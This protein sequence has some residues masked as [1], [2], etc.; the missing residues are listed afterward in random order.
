M[1]VLTNKT[2]NE[3][4]NYKEKY[5]QA[6][7]EIQRKEYVIQR[8]QDKL[9]AIEKH[10]KELSKPKKEDLL[11]LVDSITYIINQ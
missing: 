6:Y 11:D 1:R 4:N 9:N 10:I 8:K 2:Y 5:K 7:N 3:L